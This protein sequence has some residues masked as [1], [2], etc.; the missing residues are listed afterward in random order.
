MRNSAKEV[1]SS[2]PI[3]VRFA[4]FQS[5]TLRLANAGWELSVREGRSDIWGEHQLQLAMT[6][7]GVN[8]YVI[9]H[10]IR[11]ENRELYRAVSEPGFYATYVSGLCFEIMAMAPTIQFHRVPTSFGTHVSRFSDLF[12]PI[13]ASP[14]LAEF[15]DMKDF[16]FFRTANP[17][18]KDIIVLPEMVPDLLAKVLEAQGPMMDEIKKRER[19]R[20]NLE[21]YRAAVAAHDLPR[22]K[23][24]HEVQLQLVTLSGVA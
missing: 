20:E 17:S 9:S 4:G 21:Q 16:R 8:Q 19:S 10:P 5:D 23:P 6:H 1:L 11:I 24:A 18:V 3:P 15:E 14:Q 12:Q 7:R 13:D 22:I 2:F